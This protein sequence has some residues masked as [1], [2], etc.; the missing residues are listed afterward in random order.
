MLFK[1]V[2]PFL[3]IHLLDLIL[4]LK[5]YSYDKTNTYVLSSL[6]L[7]SVAMIEHTRVIKSLSTI[8]CYLLNYY[9]YTIIQ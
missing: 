7:M 3:Q 2:F 6:K 4:K 8:A 9:Q 5:Q 1:I